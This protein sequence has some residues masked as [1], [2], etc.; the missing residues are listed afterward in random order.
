MTR[1]GEL[2][3]PLWA[4]PWWLLFLGLAVAEVVALG[5]RIDRVPR[6]R[7]WVRAAQVVRAELQSSDAMTVAPAWA[8]PLLRLYLGD[9]ITPR[10]AG[11]VDLA[12]FE[13]LWVLSIRGAR[14]PEAPPRN[15]DFTQIVGQVMVQRYDFGPTPVV[16]DLVDVLP[17][18]R[19]H[20]TRQDQ[21]VEC[22]FRERTRGAARGGLGFG[23][24]VPRERFVCDESKPWLWVGTTML[25]DLSLSPRRCIWQHPQGR[26]PVS[27]TF[28]DVPLGRTL[29]LH[30]GLDYHDERDG[31][32]APVTL[33]ALVD[34]QEIGRLVHRDEDGWVRVELSTRLKSRASDAPRGVLTIEVTAPSAHH[35]SLCWSGS[36]RD[37]TRRE[38]P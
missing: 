19:V 22:P 6:D 18:A 20:V 25:E 30:A 14:S 8:D 10:V 13:R 37:T 29:V 15:P 21:P 17:S 38:A 16:L 4:S 5:A 27:V 7:D 26:E 1:S 2:R 34:G 28:L 36:I 32:G 23:P 12:P 3:V 33:R 24:V 35:R 9:R 31:Q 11:R